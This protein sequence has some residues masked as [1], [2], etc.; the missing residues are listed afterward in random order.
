MP[1]IFDLS[2]P[3]IIGILTVITMCLGASP[4]FIYL[5]WQQQNRPLGAALIGFGVILALAGTAEWWFPLV[6]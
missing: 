2:I 4:W 3:D 5:G 6:Q 1:S